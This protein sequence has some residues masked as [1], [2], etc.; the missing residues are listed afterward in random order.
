MKIKLRKGRVF[1]T[2]YCIDCDDLVRF[3]D[4]IDDFLGHRKIEVKVK[5][6]KVIE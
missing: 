6:I 2:H 1:E 5:L 3:G 4:H